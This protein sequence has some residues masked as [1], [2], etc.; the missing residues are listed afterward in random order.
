MR[1]SKSE[2]RRV[3]GIVHIESALWIY[4][5]G[6]IANRSDETALLTSFGS[7]YLYFALRL[8]YSPFSQLSDDSRPQTNDSASSWIPAKFAPSRPWKKVMLGRPLNPMYLLRS[9]LSRG[10]VGLFL[11]Q[12]TVETMTDLKPQI[13][14]RSKLD[15]TV[16]RR[17]HICN[18]RGSR[19]ITNA[20][21][22]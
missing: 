14:P 6:K 13:S 4:S 10:T 22:K 19:L 5:T 20:P 16:E 9:T 15:I 21:G 17:N 2:H 12:V 1:V 8:G 3:M 18:N 7:T 11:A